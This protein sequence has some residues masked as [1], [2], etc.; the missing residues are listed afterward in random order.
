MTKVAITKSKEPPEELIRVAEQ[1]LAEV[2]TVKDLLF[3]AEFLDDG[4]IGGFFPEDK[5]LIID[6][7]HCLTNQM[8]MEKGLMHIPSIWFNML[9]ALYH[10]LAHAK[11]LMTNP[12][13]SQEYPLPQAHEHAADLEAMA[14]IRAWI[15]DNQIPTLEEMGWVGE[16][17]KHMINMTYSQ[18]MGK[19]LVEELDILNIGGVVLANILATHQDFSE[20]GQ[21]SLYEMIDTGE[22]GVKVNNQRYLK[23]AEFFESIN[24]EQTID[25]QPTEEEEDSEM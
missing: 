17:V 7:G 12:N 18:D 16:Q 22:I 6:L 15:A 20:K 14:K 1:E 2:A 3:E 19:Q 10:E 9:W 24:R 11:Q 21:Q 13:L 5:M 25:E 23:A 4:A 8:F